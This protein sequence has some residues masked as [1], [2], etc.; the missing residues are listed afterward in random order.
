MIKNAMWVGF[1]VMITFVK[2]RHSG[3]QKVS[4]STNWYEQ[5]LRL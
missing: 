3:L 2:Y 1:S 5:S 4:A